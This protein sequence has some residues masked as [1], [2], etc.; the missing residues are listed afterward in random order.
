MGA[1]VHSGSR[2]FY[3]ARQSVPPVSF[4][5]AW[6]FSCAPSSRRVHSGSLGFIR[7]R[8]GGPG[9]IRVRVGSLER[10]KWSLRVHSG[11]LVFN[12]GRICDAGFSRVRLGF[13]R[14]D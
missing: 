12:L 14:R 3:P 2:R 6:V 11:S 10:A 13:L 4:G 5:F 7:V 8:L 1:W 9:F